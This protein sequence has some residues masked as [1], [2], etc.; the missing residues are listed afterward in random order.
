MPSKRL[1]DVLS[2][3]EMV[4]INWA[5]PMSHLT[6]DMGGE[7]EGELGESM[8]AHGI[9]QYFTASEAAWQNGLVRRNG[10]IWKAAARKA[11]KYVGARGFVDMRR[12]A[13]MVNWAKNARINSSGYS[14]A[15]WVI[16]RGYKLPWSPLDEKQSGE[17]ASLE[18]PDYSPE[19]GRRLSWLRAAGVRPSAHT[20]GIVNGE[21]NHVWRKV[22]KNRTDARTALVTHRWYGP[23]IVVGKEKN[24]V[25]VS[26]RGRVTEVAPECLRKASVAEQMSWDISAK[27]KALFE[28]A[29]N[30][31]DSSWEEP[32]L[33][34]SGRSLDTEMPDMAAEPPTLQGEDSPPVIDDDDGSA[35]SETSIDEDEDANEGERQVNEPDLVTEESREMESDQLR[36]C[37]TTKQ[38]RKMGRVP[39]P[40]H[41]EKEEVEP[42][43]KKARANVSELLHDAFLAKSARSKETQW[44]GIIGREKLLFLEAVSKQR[45]AWQ[46]NAAATVILMPESFGAR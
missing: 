5:G 17:L 38:S 30:G 31:E 34:E 2:V 32:M 23:A 29:L 44:H 24:N 4:W 8:E 20:Q 25:F 16:G 18:L 1:D 37:L 14:P 19:F 42:R 3:H 13:S 22:K 43:L 26:H 12:L 27:E 28:K 9:R 7:F 35:V 46:E 21:L 36:R 33:D 40:S 39:E 45:N 41:E 15:Q 11:I 10:G 6:S